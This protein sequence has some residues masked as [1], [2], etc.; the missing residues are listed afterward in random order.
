MLPVVHP[1]R[2]VPVTLKPKLQQK[3]LSMEKL[4]A[5]Q[6]AN[7]LTE[8]VNSMV[9]IVKPNG[10]LQICIDPRDLNKDIK[11]EHFLMRKIDEISHECQTPRSFPS[12]MQTQAFGK[13][14]WIHSALSC[15]HSIPLLEEC[16]SF[17]LP[18]SQDIFHKLMPQTF[19]DI[20]DV[21]VVVD[22]LLIWGESA[23]QHDSH[24]M[25]VFNKAKK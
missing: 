4:D 23:Q 25:Q 24:L 18:S 8:W 13:S 7:K 3:L 20:E 21:E 14:G 19:E 16:L 2:K 1:P 6:K 22:D 9:T 5:I 17:G 15:A 10:N 11:R 12:S